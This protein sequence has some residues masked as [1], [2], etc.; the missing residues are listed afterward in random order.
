VIAAWERAWLRLQ[1]DYQLAILSSFAAC[2]FVG[3]FPFAIYRFATGNVLAGTVD[4]AIVAGIVLAVVHAW[5][6]GKRSHACL[7]LA[8]INTV[9]CLLSASV[10]GPPG[11][12]WMYPA[13]LGNFLLLSRRQAVLVTVVALTLLT[14]QG[15]AYESTAQLFMFLVSAGV[16]GL[17]AFVFASRTETQRLELEALATLDSLTGVPNRRAMEAELANAVAQQHSGHGHFGL[18]MLDIDHFKRIND[19]HGHEA[20]DE[21]LVAFA[22]LVRRCI[23]GSDRCFRFGGEEF[24]LL[25]PGMER[26]ALHE[27]DGTLRRRVAAELSCHG[28]AVTVSIGA[29]V[30]RPDE[31]WQAWLARADAALYRA[32][33]EG[34]N[35]TVV[36]DPG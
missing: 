25:L 27:I 20:G 16:S 11:L 29:A 8:V 22:G 28:E 18:A 2:G 26:T 17:V 7:L 30:L 34:R 9:G 31:D 14:L 1:T 10:L 33:H 15:E 13:L 23:R 21:V 32:K 19:E 4:T 24:V 5:N 36:D 12:F 3:I 6:G 35:R